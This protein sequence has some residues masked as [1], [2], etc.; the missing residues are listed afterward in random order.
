MRGSRLRHRGVPRGRGDELPG[1]HGSGRAHRGDDRDDPFAAVPTV[2]TPNAPPAPAPPTGGG[3]GS[4]P[5]PPATQG[6]ASTPTTPTASTPSHSSDSNKPQPKDKG[7][8]Q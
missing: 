3:E 1:R 8:R 2:S 6:P 4:A 7:S 5:P